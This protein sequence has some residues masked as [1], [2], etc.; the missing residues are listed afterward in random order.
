MAE[1]L[2]AQFGPDELKNG[3]NK[4]EWG[5]DVIALPDRRKRQAMLEEFGIRRVR[6][7]AA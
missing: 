2:R 3:A 7:R 5:P 1:Y 6:G 4:C